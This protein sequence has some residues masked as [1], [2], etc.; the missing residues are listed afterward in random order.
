M[1]RGRKAA[2]PDEEEAYEVQSIVDWR[3][4]LKGKLE[5]YVHW[6]GYK[7][8]DDNTWEPMANLEEGASEALKAFIKTHDIERGPKRGRPS[9]TS[10]KPSSVSRRRSAAGAENGEAHGKEG[11][12]KRRKSETASNGASAKKARTAKKAQGSEEDGDA[13]LAEGFLGDEEEDNGWDE[14]FKNKKSWED[15]VESII[16]AERDAND[17]IKMQIKWTDGTQKWINNEVA[18]AKCPQKLIDFYQNHLT[19]TTQE[20][21]V[22]GE[23]DAAVERAMAGNETE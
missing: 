8:P 23:V 21:G 5:F 10:Q 16:T 13:D 18:R 1:P 11:K 19:F 17:G 6:K 9:N 20:D 22:D 7:N 3:R 15:L 14:Q 2:S 12:N 4:T